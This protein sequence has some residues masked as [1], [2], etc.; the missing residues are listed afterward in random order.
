MG[1]ATQAPWPTAAPVPR[2]PAAA[3]TAD[4]P[5]GDTLGDDRARRARPTRQAAPELGAC[6]Q[7]VQD[8]PV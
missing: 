2:R 1:P 4:G 6:P 3:M 5:E 8:A 7:S